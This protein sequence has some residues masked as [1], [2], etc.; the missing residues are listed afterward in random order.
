VT[1][2]ALAIVRALD[3]AACIGGVVR[4]LRQHCPDLDVVVVDDGSTDD[5]A[6]VAAAAGARVVSLPFNLGM[7]GA[8]Q[9]GYRL[10]RDEGYDV[11]VQLDGDGQHPA[12]EAARLVAALREGG[13]DMVVGSRFADGE[14]YRPPALRRL[15]IRVLSGVASAVLGRRVTDATSGLKAVGR[16]GIAL[17]AAHHPHD[18]VEIE[19]L[20]MA[21]RHGLRVTE[22]PV[23]MRARTAGRSSI[24]PGRTSVYALRAALGLA[25]VLAGRRAAPEPSG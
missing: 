22:L 4:E 14:G 3:E 11:A 25:V 5:T 2:K 12:A 20:L 13:A 21:A 16:E 17:F 1:I 15:G 8:V 18:Y 19:S 24:T 6:R 7:G 9:T 10:A 23:A